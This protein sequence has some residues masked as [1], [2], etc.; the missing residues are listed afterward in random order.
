MKTGPWAFLLVLSFTVTSAWGSS[1][2]PS[3]ILVDKKT[4]SLHVAEYQEEEYKIHKTFHAT[5]GR[6]KGDKQDEGDLK[7]PEGVYFFSSYLTPPT[8]KAKFGNM[9]FYMDYPNPYDRLAGYTGFDIMLH[10]TNE[11]GRLKFD[12]DSEGCIVVNNDQIEE[13]KP[14]IR[15]GMTPILVFSELTSDLRK[16]GG[17]TALKTFFQGWIKAWESKD[18]DG[19]MNHY[20]SGFTSVGKDKAGWRAHKNGLN[21]RY[22]TIEVGMHNVQYYRHPKY[23]MIM[24]VQNYRS[25]LKNGRVGFTSSGTKILYV[26]EED[27]EHKIISED[28]TQMVRQSY[29]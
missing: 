28:F 15:L 8:L 16:P 20:H 18:I 9:A 14:Y 21:Q 24:F 27:G 26:A 2:F 11:P 17:D 29:L 6:V 25:K 22:E 7:T 5:V 12:Y 13:V 23:S 1:N 3:V 4:N 10:A 19:Y